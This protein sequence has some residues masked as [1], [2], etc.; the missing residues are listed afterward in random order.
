MRVTEYLRFWSQGFFLEAIMQFLPRNCSESSW[1]PQ[2]R[3]VVACYVV[4]FCCFHVSALKDHDFGNDL[5]ASESGIW[6]YRGGS[7]T[8]PCKWVE[9]DTESYKVG[10]FFLFSPG[11]ASASVNAW[12]FVIRTKSSSAWDSSRQLYKFSR[13]VARK[14]SLQHWPPVDPQRHRHPSC[15]NFSNLIMTLSLFTVGS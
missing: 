8:S 13:P 4:T 1:R 9:P 2:W 7:K 11:V 15:V 12:I 10:S 6:W 5:E 14:R 3:P